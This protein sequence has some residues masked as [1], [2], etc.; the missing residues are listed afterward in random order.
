MKTRDPGKI[1]GNSS[2]YL[3]SIP[4]DDALELSL[5]PKGWKAF[6][7]LAHKALDEA[8]EFVERVRERPVWQPMPAEVHAE[9]A[10]PLSIDETPLETLYHQFKVNCH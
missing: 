10:Q 6:R 1:L 5:D 4:L 7:S 3:T 8:L 2:E 9:L